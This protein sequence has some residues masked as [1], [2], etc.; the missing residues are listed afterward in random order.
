M[1]LNTWTGRIAPGNNLNMY[2]IIHCIFF[3]T[4]YLFVFIIQLYNIMVDRTYIMRSIIYRK[5]DNAQGTW[6]LE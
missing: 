1:C 4:M 6:L 2:E 5:C 3:L